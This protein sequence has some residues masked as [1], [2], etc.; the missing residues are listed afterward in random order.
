VARKIVARKQ[1]DLE[2]LRALLSDWGVTGAKEEPDGTW[3]RLEAHC[4]PK[5]GGYT[6]FFVGFSFDRWGKFVGI[7]VGE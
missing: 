4:H 2:R 1:T 6:G 5:V 3:L 7:E